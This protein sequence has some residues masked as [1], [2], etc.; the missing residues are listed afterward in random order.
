MQILELYFQFAGVTL[1]LVQLVLIVRDAWDVRP[2]RFGAL[3]VISLIY[4]VGADASA[5]AYIPGWLHYGLSALSMNTAIFIWWFALSLFDDEFRLRRLEWA[6]AIVWFILGVFNFNEFILDL[7][8]SAPWAAYARS[9]MALGIVAHIVY[10]ALA[11]RQT[12]LIEGRRRVRVLFAF[13]IAALF[14]V[15]IGSELGFGWHEEPLWFSTIEHGL[16]FAVILWSSFW[17]F[18]LDKHVLMFDP[19]AEPAETPRQALSPKEQ[20]LHQKLIGVVE[21]EKAFLEPELSISALASRIGAP[22]HQLRTLINKAMG[23]RNFRAF[24][25]GYRMAEAKAALA[26]PQK[27]AQPILTIAMDAGFASLSSF[28]RAFK[29]SVGQTPTAFRQGALGGNPP[30]QN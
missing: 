25:N 21:T 5:A 11:G 8:I 30:P 15:D 2:A 23:H 1:L 17:L 22:E 18:R 9:V 3:L 20:L 24:L 27:A 16:I 12:D 19:A 28:N 7:P 10:R 13:A 6:V 29:E 14:L 26:D 4:I